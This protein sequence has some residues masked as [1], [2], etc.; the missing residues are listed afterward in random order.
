[1]SDGSAGAARS[2]TIDVLLTLPQKI[3]AVFR[4]EGGLV[5]WITALAV[6]VRPVGAYEEL[7]IWMGWWVPDFMSRSAPEPW[8]VWV[9]GSTVAVSGPLVL[10][11]LIVRRWL[12]PHQVAWQLRKLYRYH[13][14]LE[15]DGR[16]RSRGALYQF[17]LSMVEE[18]ITRLLEAQSRFA[19][20]RFTTQVSDTER[21]PRPP[22]PRPGA[23]PSETPNARPEGEA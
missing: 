7:G 22:E 16:P 17:E 15:G 10:V 6:L 12:Y 9:F 11:S 20:E 5:A 1:M 18:A 21:Q 14:W 19:T 2:G 23:L 8:M 4:R 13:T 3:M